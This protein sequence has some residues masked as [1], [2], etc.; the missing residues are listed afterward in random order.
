M[1]RFR[2]DW[3]VAVL[4]EYMTWIGWNIQMSVLQWPPNSSDL[5]PIENEEWN[6]IALCKKKLYIVLEYVS[7]ISIR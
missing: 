5:N 6:Y 3:R 2:K 7:L 4:A 1:G